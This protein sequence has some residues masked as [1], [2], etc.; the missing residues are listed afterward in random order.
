VY[1]SRFATLTVDANGRVDVSAIQ[2]TSQTAN[3]VGGDVDSILADTGTDGVAISASGADTVWDE[4]IEDAG[5]TYTGR[6]IMA[7]L[8]AVQAGEWSSSSGVA[9]FR[10]PGN[11]ENRVVGTIG[12]TSR[13]TITITC[14]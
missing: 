3:D 4:V 6:C 8:L 5:T 12:A 1:P 9:T 7:A 10:D 11:N 14:P 13:G 2:G